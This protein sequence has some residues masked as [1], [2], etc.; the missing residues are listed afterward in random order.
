MFGF[1][2]LSERLAVMLNEIVGPFYS[3][4]ECFKRQ[5]RPIQIVFSVQR[6]NVS[7]EFAIRTA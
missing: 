6:S 7:L 1:I 2:N 5:C 3:D 4:N